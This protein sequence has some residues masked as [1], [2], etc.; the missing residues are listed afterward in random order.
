MLIPTNTGTWRRLII[1]CVSFIGVF[2]ISIAIDLACGPEPDPYDYYI[3]FFHNTIQQNDEYQ[4]FYFNGY[5]FLN[6]DF[7]EN[8]EKEKEKEQEVNAGEWAIYLGNGVKKT[9]VEHAMYRLSDSV[10]SILYNKYL[11][12][13]KLPDSLKENTFLK[14]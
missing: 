4:P 3:S 6:G 8:D 14:N 9:D 13:H 5:T 11:I 12:Y 1:Y 2:F 7:Y 10:E